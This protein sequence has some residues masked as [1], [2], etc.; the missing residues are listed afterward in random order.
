MKNIQMRDMIR[1][2]DL[3]CPCL[4][5]TGMGLNMNDID[6]DYC[7]KQAKEGYARLD[8]YIYPALK[9]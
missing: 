4:R 7:K 6:G 3:R 1:R 8:I 9:T 5:E 2:V